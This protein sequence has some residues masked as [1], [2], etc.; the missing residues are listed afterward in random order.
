MHKP[1][2]S[3][4]YHPDELITNYC[5]L[6]T[7]LTPL[8]PDCIDEHNKRHKSMNQFPEIDTLNR[9]KAMCHN[10]LSVASKTLEDQ[11]TRLNAATS[12]NLDDLVK[13]SLNEIENLRI[14]LINQINSYFGTIQNEYVS[15]IRSSEL[16]INDYRDL[17]AEISSIIEELNSVRYSLDGPNS[18][19]SI[20]STVRLDTDTLLSTFDKQVEDALSKSVSLPIKFVLNEIELQNFQT[21]LKKIISVFSQDV[22]VVTNEQYLKSLKPNLND[23]ISSQNKS[24]FNYKFKND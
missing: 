20:R 18:F 10:R 13:K 17:K 8:C 5:C 21:V 24:Y 19:D 3:C 15:K 11:L 22:K 12:L 6:R 4:Q 2:F 16:M 14:N 9:V 7:C 23:E 1:R